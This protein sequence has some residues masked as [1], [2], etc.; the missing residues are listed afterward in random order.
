MKNG[1]QRDP[2]LSVRSKD[3]LRKNFE[4]LTSRRLEVSLIRKK[5]R[6]PRYFSI[7]APGTYERGVRL[8]VCW[9]SFVSDWNHEDFKMKTDWLISFHIRLVTT[10]I[11][12]YLNFLEAILDSS[13]I[14]MH[15]FSTLFATLTGCIWQKPYIINDSKSLSIRQISLC[16]ILRW[17]LKMPIYYEVPYT[18]Y[19]EVVS[20]GSFKGR[21][22]RWWIRRIDFFNVDFLVADLLRRRH[23]RTV[24]VVE[25]FWKENKY[26][27]R[28]PQYLRANKI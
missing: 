25:R 22:K 6:D 23:R 3:N 15:R 19:V 5:L 11:Q 8:I 17:F 1:R 20:A 2:S 10:S 14:I 18:T 21:C 13:T 16:L 27:L 24:F 12:D 4:F 28:T 9:P 7:L 26:M